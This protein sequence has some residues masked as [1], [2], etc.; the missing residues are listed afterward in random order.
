MADEMPPS[1]SSTL[2]PSSRAP[3]TPEPLSP[4][5]RLAFQILN[6]STA[7]VWLAM[8][9]APRSRLT[10]ALVRLTTP[11]LAGLGLSYTALLALGIAGGER[12]D[13][14][15]PDGLRRA[16]ASPDA[17]LAGWTHYL[18][19]DLFVGRWIWRSALDHG[20][21]ARVA[22][23]LTWL[24]GPAGLTVHLAQRRRWG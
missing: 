18:A 3:A 6:A 14:T 10:E 7:P 11:L 2:Q 5:R 17:F 13:V 12:V 23:L 1:E 21:S 22:L 8:I 16:L 19:F 20:R 24:A 4:G 15:D 9:V